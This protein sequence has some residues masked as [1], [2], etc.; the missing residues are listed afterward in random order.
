M[1]QGG[2]ADFV[3]EDSETISVTVNG[4]T[5]QLFLA[6]DWEN[7]RSTLTWIDAERNF[8]FT[9]WLLSTKPTYWILLRAY[10]WLK[11]QRSE[12]F[13][14]TDLSLYFFSCNLDLRVMLCWRVWISFHPVENRF[15]RLSLL[16]CRSTSHCYDS[17]RVVCPFIAVNHHHN[18]ALSKRAR[19]KTF[20]VRLK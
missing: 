11:W 9:L 19:E 1:S 18:T 10:L 8:Q 12:L 5:G 6:K 15:R 7:T 17:D 2:V 16:L 3:T 14:K 20:L 4:M 13:E